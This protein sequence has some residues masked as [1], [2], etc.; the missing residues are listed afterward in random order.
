MIKSYRF[1]DYQRER[2]SGRSTMSFK[3]VVPAITLDSEG[4]AIATPVSRFQLTPV[5]S[6]RLIQPYV[7]VRFMDQ[8]N[9]V[10][11]TRGGG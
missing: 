10:P 9:P 7:S 3:R 6:M 4:N 5:E 1:G 2:R 8:V 11:S